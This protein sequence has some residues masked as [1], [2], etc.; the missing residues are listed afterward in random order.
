MCEHWLPLGIANVSLSF[1]L[2][3]LHVK[4]I[5]WTPRFGITR[6]VLRRRELQTK[7]TIHLV[8]GFYELKSKRLINLANGKT[9][10]AAA[11]ANLFGKSGAVSR[12]PCGATIYWVLFS[13]RAPLFA[14]VL[15]ANGATLTTDYI[16]GPGAYGAIAASSY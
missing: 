10:Y 8:C 13:I 12:P 7:N 6:A 11:P 15:V 16:A 1:L 5:N 3:M 9:F 2:Q 14:F 4:N